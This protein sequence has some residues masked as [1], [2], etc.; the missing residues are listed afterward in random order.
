MENSRH[1][2]GDRYKLKISNSNQNKSLLS[3][4]IKMFKQLS[5]KLHR[6]NKL[7]TNQQLLIPSVLRARGRN[8]SSTLHQQSTTTSANNNTTTTPPQQPQTSSSPNQTTPPQD[9]QET[10]PKP[11]ERS[12]IFLALDP[13]T[14]KTLSLSNGKGLGVALKETQQKVS[15]ITQT[16]RALLQNA[17]IFKAFTIFCIL[18]LLVVEEYMK[19]SRVEQEFTTKI[20]DEERDH[21]ERAIERKKIEDE[22]N[23]FALGSINQ[24]SL[25][26]GQ[27]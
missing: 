11:Q 7:S 20:T 26:C 19:L 10:T 9:Q 27:R 3:I 8:F 1:F 18:G 13:E 23:E 25:I 22:L 24:Y 15:K 2:F 21:A 12:N 4:K 16:F 5:F 17:W 6:T 14:F